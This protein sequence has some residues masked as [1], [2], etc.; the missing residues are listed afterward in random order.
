[1]PNMAQRLGLWTPGSPLP[2]PAGDCP[3]PHLVKMAL[4]CV[5]G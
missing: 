2:L 3:S 5:K 1:M 4:W